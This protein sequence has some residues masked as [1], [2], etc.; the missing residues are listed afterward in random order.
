MTTFTINNLPAGVT[1]VWK[2]SKFISVI[3]SN[4]TSITIKSPGGIGCVEA[5]FL[6]QTLR[7]DFWGGKP[8]SYSISVTAN[9]TNP[10][11]TDFELSPPDATQKIALEGV[12]NIEWRKISSLPSSGPVLVINGNNTSGHGVWTTNAWTINAQ[13]S[14]TNDCGTTT[15]QFVITCPTF[16]I[17]N[18]YPPLNIYPNP[19]N[20]IL[21]IGME[22]EEIQ[23][24]TFAVQSAPLNSAK[25][26]NSVYI[27]RLLDNTGNIVMQTETSGK[28]VQFN[29]IM[30]PG[31]FY[32]I[33]VLDKNTNAIV[34]QQTVV[35]QH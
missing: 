12:T 5:T 22:Q 34:S 9:P 1:P 15:Q 29:T 7:K 13:V 17:N 20:D 28:N 25:S 24:E 32:Y 35:I 33:H 19:A 3:S 4:N 10:N 2:V 21:N 6:N 23:Q 27:I 31:G 14:F 30:L 26:E 18:L 11:R 16:T 8:S